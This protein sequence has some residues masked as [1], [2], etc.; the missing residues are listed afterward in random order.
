MEGGWLPKKEEEETTEK[1]EQ[2]NDDVSKMVRESLN[3]TNVSLRK[4]I[5]QEKKL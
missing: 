1:S 3:E 4:L 2:E 5:F